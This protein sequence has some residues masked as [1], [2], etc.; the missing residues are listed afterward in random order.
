MDFSPENTSVPETIQLVVKISRISVSALIN[1]KKT[2]LMLNL[3]ILH[4]HFTVQIL[5]KH[6][7]LPMCTSISD[8][9]AVIVN[10]L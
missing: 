4:V 1:I 10:N 9:T 2:L 6:D 8:D 3:Y 7:I 5:T